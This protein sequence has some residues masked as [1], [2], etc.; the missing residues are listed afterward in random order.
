MF[1]PSV[2]VVLSQTSCWRMFR[3]IAVTWRKPYHKSLLHAVPFDMMLSVILLII[4]LFGWG[5]TLASDALV[6][7]T[8]ASPTE[9]ARNTIA[10]AEA[11]LGPLIHEVT[12]VL[13]GRPASIS[14][15]VS[16]CSCCPKLLP[17]Y[18]DPYRIL[19]RVTSAHSGQV[20]LYSLLMTACL[21]RPGSHVKGLQSP[22]RLGSCS[23]TGSGGPRTRWWRLCVCAGSATDIDAGSL[24]S[25]AL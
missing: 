23:R 7:S 17:P 24:G 6:S 9:Y 15:L 14:A 1:S 21:W 11:A 5:P 25:V 10:R 12:A 20:V 19:R 2:G 18:T 4:F 13:Y 3:L 16:W 8:V 22:P